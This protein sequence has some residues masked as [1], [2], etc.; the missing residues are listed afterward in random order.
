M[1]PD[2]RAGLLKAAA[3][4]RYDATGWRKQ[5]CDPWANVLDVTAVGIEQLAAKVN[6]EPGESAVAAYGPPFTTDVP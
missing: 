1:T 6:D 4:C 2:F 3:M 5:N